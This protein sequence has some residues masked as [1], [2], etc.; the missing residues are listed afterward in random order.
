[1]FPMKTPSD[2]I[3]AAL[4]EG[5]QSLFEH[6]AKEIVRA[7][8]IIV[9]KSSLVVPH[10]V[11]TILS[12]AEKLGFPLAIKAVSSEILHKTEAGAV[13]LNVANSTALAKAVEDMKAMIAERVPGAR[14]RFFLLEKMMPSGL[15]LFF[16]GLRDEQFGPSVTFGLGGVW[17]EALKDA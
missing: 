3:Q 8:G 14:I 10:D 15:E 17:V 13:T 16:G 9:P 4:K 11:K 1:M 2:I 7:V 12:A 6:E 5:R